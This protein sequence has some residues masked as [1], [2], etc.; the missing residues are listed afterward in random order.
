MR[1]VIISNRLPVRVEENEGSYNFIRSEGGLATGLS[2]L[3]TNDEIVWIGWPGI[4]VEDKQDKQLISKEL[5]KNKF[6][7]VYLTPEHILGF[8]EGYSNSTIW[9]L[10]HY[11]Y[12][13]IE[14]DNHYW[15]VYQEV[16]MLFKE[17]ASEVIQPDDM[18]WVQDYQLMLLPG[19]LRESFP[20]IGIGYFHHIPFPS[21][22]LFRVLPERAKILKG[23]LGADLIGFHTYDYMRHF[24]SAA[25]RVLGLDFQ[26]DEI[27]YEGRKV[28]VDSFPMG[29]NFK[30]HFNASLDPEIKK[31]IDS[32]RTEFGEHSLILSVDRLDY[33]KGIL[34]RLKGFENFIEQYPE[35]RSEVSLVMIVVPS[36]DQVDRYADLKSKIDETIGN[37]NGKYS[38]LNW[39]P[40]IYF[41]KSFPFNELMALYHIAD[42]AL[43]SPLR[44]GMN[45]VAKEY[46]AVKRNS[47]GVLILSEMAGAAIELKD[48]IIINPNDVNEITNA[49]VEAIQMPIDEKESRLKNMQDIVSRQNINKWTTNF[50][51][52]LQ[53]IKEKRQQIR[54]KQL[55]INTINTIKDQYIAA[56]NRLIVLDYDGTLVPL[57]KKPQM[58]APDNNLIMILKQLSADPGNKVVINSGRDPDTLDRW[59]GNLN[60]LLAAE[61]G[62]FYKEKGTWHENAQEKPTFGPEIY[63]IL[64]YI[65]DKTPG[66]HIETKK[67]SVVWHFRNCDAWLAD[68][69]EKQLIDALM[70]PC[71]R[72][73]LQIMKG[74]KVVEIKSPSIHKGIEVMRLVN[75]DNFDFI[76]AMGDDIT[77]EDMFHSLPSDTI[78]IK[79]GIDSEL[80]RYN[81]KSPVESV[82]FLS[83]LSQL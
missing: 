24:I 18:V 64:N 82:A 43:V 70:V 58:A 25:Y 37:I 9:P 36:R 11:F 14:Y 22:E 67:L 7:P 73:N 5:F 81:L 78:T 55:N 80:A 19:F 29:I 28:H 68:M 48:S 15:N 53:N 16:N 20:E 27:N 77:D 66:S 10:C 57:V 8:Y 76:L 60:L 12:S 61:H 50:I 33:S 62:A 31:N 17:V 52:E 46:I 47:P 65:T 69:R 13:Y 51:V 41:Y 2:S 6:Y 56:K 40:I 34:H 59:L 72:Y 23:L 3:Q 39:Q 75:E 74:N 45:L 21:Y 1:I 83:E 35:Y 32:L 26:M 4:Y 44:D 30:Q 54:S 49:L 42:V 79:I 38:T 63:D 71:S